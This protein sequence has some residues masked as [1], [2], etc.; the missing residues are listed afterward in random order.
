MYQERIGHLASANV[1]DTKRS[2]VD[3]LSTAFCSVVEG[4]RVLFSFGHGIGKHFISFGCATTAFI[5]NG[6][7]NR[8]KF[9]AF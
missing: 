4:E 1:N 3:Q 9:F 5:D 2:A 6:Y 7:R 8:Q